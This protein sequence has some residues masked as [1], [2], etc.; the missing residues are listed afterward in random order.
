MQTL[1]IALDWTPNT[2]HVGIFVAQ[3]LGFYEEL[4]LEVAIVHPLADNYQVS[5]GKKLEL[6]EVDFSIA[7]FE[8]V[9][10]LNNKPNKVHA[11]AIFALLQEDLS[12][13][14]SLKGGE[15]KRMKDL[16]G[17]IYAS[18]KARYEDLIVKE[19]IKA[20]GGAGEPVLQYP[21]RLGIWNTL[22]EGKADATWIFDNWEGVEAATHGVELRK[23]YLSQHGIPYGYSPV[24]F[25][26]KE[27]LE[28]NRALYSHFVEAT[29]RGYL[30]A[31][32]NQSEACQIL[33]PHLTPYDQQQVDLKKSLE[34]SAPFFGD[35][36]T[37]GKMKPARV[38]AFLDW[39]VGHG[40]EDSRILKQDLYL[41]ELG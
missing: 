22:L 39:L 12:C 6:D 5:P 29:R 17:K 24:I 1:S 20:D 2:N 18:Y 33:N 23:F 25:T 32:S 14:V 36:A 40:L 41:N 8:T 21:D 37:C 16:D 10:S 34:V 15:I 3:Q 13:I 4:G 30:H 11:V 7:P 19:M 26:K 9:I 28:A 38:Q 35:A 27:S 31:S